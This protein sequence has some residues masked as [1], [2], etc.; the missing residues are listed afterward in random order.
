MA[1]TARDIVT[2][3]LEA[4]IAEAEAAKY[5]ADV[6]GRLFLEKA[7]QLFRTVRSNEDI[8]AELISSAE[9]IDPDGDYMFMRP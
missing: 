6:V 2:P 8:A 7:I 9:N 5:D 4:A 3:H 1:G